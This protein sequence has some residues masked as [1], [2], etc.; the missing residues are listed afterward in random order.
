MIYLAMVIT[1]LFM[2]GCSEFRDYDLDAIWTEK[3][4]ELPVSSDVPI[5]SNS[6]T[7]AHY[8]STVDEYS[9]NSVENP[10]IGPY[11][12]SGSSASI[13]SSSALKSSSSSS[14]SV[15]AEYGT[16]EDERDSNVYKT[17]QI[18]NQTWMAEN[19]RYLPSLNGTEDSEE[20]AKY[21]VYGYEG[22]DVDNAK[23]TDNYK[24]YGVL[25][26]FV[27]AKVACPAGWHLPSNTEWNAL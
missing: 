1:A 22:S 17:V 8:S 2:S 27:A 21:Y 19:L 6:E 7:E 20:D 4:V 14:S 15:V 13:S 18:G 5:S 10:D 9:S 25:Y 12:S 23:N 26:N 24:T 11:L 3:G 16:F